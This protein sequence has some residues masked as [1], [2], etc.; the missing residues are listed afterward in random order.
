MYKYFQ[1]IKTLH[2]KTLNEIAVLFNRN[3]IPYMITGGQAVVQ[4]GI[5][6]FT[7]DIDITISLHPDEELSIVKIVEKKFNILSKHPLKF[8]KE[9]WV[10]PIQNKETK[11][12]EAITNTKNIVIDKIPLKF[13]S[14]EN[15]IIPKIFAGRERDIEI[16]SEGI[17]Y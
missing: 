16:F 10:L 3:R 5:P 6:R 12:S 14:P 1:K 4:F 2:Q 15:L 8:V 7:Q 13:I 9:N 11:V 17:R